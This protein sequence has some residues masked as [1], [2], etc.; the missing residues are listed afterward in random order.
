MNGSYLPRIWLRISPILWISLCFFIDCRQLCCWLFLYVSVGR[1]HFVYAPSQW[2]MMLHSNVISHWLGTYTKWSP[3]VCTENCALTRRKLC[4]DWW[5]LRLSLWQSVMSPVTTTVEPL[6]N[7]IVFHQNTH[8][9]VRARY[10]VSFVSSKPDPYP[11][12]VDVVVYLI[13]AIMNR[14]I[15]RFYCRLALWQLNSFQCSIK[16]MQ[17]KSLCNGVTLL[18]F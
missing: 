16:G 5:H 18:L 17:L 6:Y 9:R 2:E 3:V 4:C 13:S 15:K 12:P 10:G 7:T 8:K 11:T 14:V 1:N